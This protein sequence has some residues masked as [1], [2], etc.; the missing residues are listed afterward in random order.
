[1]LSVTTTEPPMGYLLGQRRPVDDDAVSEAIAA[2]SE[3]MSTMR[4]MS[5][6]DCA[7]ILDRVARNIAAAADDLAA[8]LTAESGYLTRKDMN[9]EVQR[10]V[11]LFEYASA[12][13]RI[14]FTETV[15]ADAADRA[16]NAQ[17]IVRHE[18]IGPILA[19]T[20]F[21]GPLL[22]PAHKIAPAVIARAPIVLKPSPRVPK[23]GVAL[24]EHLVDA[25]W[26]AVAICVLP[27]D[28][29][30]T[31]RMIKDPRL[32]VITFTGGPFGWQIKD[33]APRKH[34]HLELGGVGAVIVAD[35]AAL[36][37]AA[38][39]CAAGG[40]IRSGQACNS[41]QRVYV[42][43]GAYERFTK[44]LTEHVMSLTIGDPADDA[45]DIGPMVDEPGAQRV[46]AMIEDAV[47]RG[48][49][50]LCGGVRD[51]ATLTPAVLC[52]VTGEM[53]IT[54]REAFGP[55]IALAP[56]DD[57]AEAIRE[58][59]A[60]DGAIQVGIYTSN[61]E[62]AYSMADA[63]H[64]GSVIINGPTSWRLDHLPYGGVGTS[65]FGREG[66]ASM[67]REYTEPKVVVL[68]RHTTQQTLGES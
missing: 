18:A 13:A 63:I 15:N 2:A 8:A 3:A 37:I 42:Q 1:M 27:V 53:Q 51:G 7:R 54:R 39:E 65:G 38:K 64:A 12:V 49:R 4:L 67:V 58:T 55:V 6:Y 17:A 66:I 26:P 29:H 41:V 36:D 5:S 9:A 47:A 23:A 45:T 52:D 32:P 19:I 16:R 43:R 25:G 68:R 34:V 20:A 14:G 28:D 35:D 57:L 40:L 56:F 10:A 22:I 46:V 21:N 44:L 61:V 48:A 33:A 30:A 59:N 31:M 50:L 62:A 24:A 60:V 11:E